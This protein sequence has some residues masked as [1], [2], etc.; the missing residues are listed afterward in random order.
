MVV[1][2]EHHAGPLPPLLPIALFF[3]G[4]GVSLSVS[5][6]SFSGSHAINHPVSHASS[7]G[8]EGR[9]IKLTTHL[10]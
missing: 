4:C 1:M 5:H 8:P 10:H 9:E 6:E 2:K 3:Q 7:E